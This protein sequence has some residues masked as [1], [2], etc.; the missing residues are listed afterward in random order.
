MSAPFRIGYV[1]GV[2][3]DKWVRV[4]RERRRDPL[5]VVLVPDARQALDD[6]QVAM[7]LARLPLDREGLHLIPLY[8]ERPV[9][10]VPADH[11]ASA[12][13][14]IALSELDDL[15]LTLSAELDVRQ[16][17]ETVAAGTGVVVLPHALARQHQR[18]DVRLVFLTDQ[19]S[20]QIGLAWPVALED[21]RVEEF[22]GVVR[23]RTTRSSRG[24]ATSP[25]E[26]RPR[27]DAKRRGSR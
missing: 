9:V 6:G 7:V 27:R 17:V 24:S 8:E 4:W 11:P 18:K 13:D 1:E 14:E 3:P 16:A 12:Y 26:A 2:T 5:E 15:R 25:S 21:D 19:D 10:V 20:T 22:I 23:G